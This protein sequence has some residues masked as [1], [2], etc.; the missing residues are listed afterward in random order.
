M[1]IR[2]QGIELG[3]TDTGG[4]DEILIENLDWSYPEVRSSDWQLEGRDGALPGRDFH[5]MRNASFDLVTNRYTME[6]ARETAARFIT[7]WR[8]KKLRDTSGTLVPLEYRALDDPRWRRVYGRPRRVDD[9]SFDILMRLGTGRITCEF[10]VFEPRVFSGGEPFETVLTKIE[11]SSSGG[12]STPFRWPL[13]SEKAAGAR[14]G[15]LEVGG[16]E[17][18]PAIITFRGPGSAFSLDGNR[19]WHVGLKKDVQLAYDECLEID[20][21][22]RTVESY[23]TDDPSRR[24]PRFG[25][26]DRRSALSRI[27]LEPGTEN[28]FFSAI[29]QTNSSSALIQWR[30]AFSTLA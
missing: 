28:V 8:D 17:P 12:W 30:E 9:P 20:P 1:Q 24:S 16:T 15:F 27:L 29:D 21:L 22:A 14:A 25:A 2:F 7:A 4:L 3:E 11:E 26:L 13:S 23:F 10:Q 18:T 19:G 5:G 6:E